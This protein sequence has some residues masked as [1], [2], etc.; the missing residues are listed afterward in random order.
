MESQEKKTS[1]TEFIPVTKNES[2][3][4]QSYIHPVLMNDS[5]IISEKKS[6]ND[7][8]RIVR[9]DRKTGSEKKILTMGTASEESVSVS[10]NFITWTEIQLP[11]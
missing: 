10:G 1:Y 2:K 4:F 11:D 7:P 3:K 9:I 5:V 6:L 8:D